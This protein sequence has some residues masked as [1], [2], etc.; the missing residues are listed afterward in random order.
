ME[1]FFIKTI[2]FFKKNK[3][4]SLKTIFIANNIYYHTHNGSYQKALKI[5]Y[6]FFKNETNYTNLILL[7]NLFLRKSYLQLKVEEPIKNIISD[8]IIILDLKFINSKETE[9][10]FKTIINLFLSS[11]RIND[12]ILYLKKYLL[13]TSVDKVNKQAIEFYIS[14]LNKFFTSREIL[15]LSQEIIFKTKITEDNI[16]DFIIDFKSNKQ[17]DNIFNTVLLNIDKRKSNLS[18]FSM[19][20]TNPI[21]NNDVDF[22]IILGY[23]KT[24]NNSPLK[25]RLTYIGELLSENNYTQILQKLDSDI[26][27]LYNKG[28]KYDAQALSSIIAKILFYCYR[29]EQNFLTFAKSAYKINSEIFSNT[30][31]EY[32]KIIDNEDIHLIYDILKDIKNRYK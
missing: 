29:D 14:F 25:L 2:N 11:G 17:T 24:L 3:F 31:K 27:K 15:N 16:L 8:L 1:S 20:L 5:C 4:R 7:H 28:Y 10:L 13:Y 26:K 23:A 18:D 6:N 32:H 21:M 12:A 9:Q 19:A 30:S 22:K